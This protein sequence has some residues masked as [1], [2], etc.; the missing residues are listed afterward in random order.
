M[1]IALLVT[2]KASPALRGALSEHLSICD[3]CRRLVAACVKSNR[4][5]L[6]S[7]V[8]EADA[9][10]ITVG[11][12]PPWLRR[13]V[14]AVAGAKLPTVP[15]GTIRQ[16]ISLEWLVWDAAAEAP[17]LAAEPQTDR[18]AGL[19]TL[20]STDRQVLVH[21]RRPDADGPILAYVICQSVA[22][23]AGLR[24]VL[25]ERG[26]SF[27]V[28]A[29]GKAELTGVTAEEL[30]GVRVQLEMAPL[31]PGERMREPPER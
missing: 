22:K 17:V 21:F 10:P 30:V 13:V 8:G 5:D 31:P 20:A 26:L 12:A 29:D 18:I 27:P 19:P 16:I 9:G 25:P 2:G 7:A 4:T 23:Y 1:Q 3:E 14:E 6:P 11:H 15:S 28:G 24:L